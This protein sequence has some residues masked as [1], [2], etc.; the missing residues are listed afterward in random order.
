M[1]EQIFLFQ[2]MNL[3]FLSSLII[4]SVGATFLTEELSLM[5]KRDAVKVVLG[6]RDPKKKKKGKWFVNSLYVM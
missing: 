5:Q 3:L 2:E 6:K 4:L 1:A